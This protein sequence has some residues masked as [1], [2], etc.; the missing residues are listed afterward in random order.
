MV[1][2]L[3]V[4]SWEQSRINIF[5]G[6]TTTEKIRCIAKFS[7]SQVMTPSVNF[8]WALPSFFGPVTGLPSGNWHS[9]SRSSPETAPASHFTLSFSFYMSESLWEH[10]NEIFPHRC[11]QRSFY[12]WGIPI[13][14][15]L[16]DSSFIVSLPSDS[17]STFSSSFM[18][19]S[20]FLQC[21]GIGQQLQE[22]LFSA[23]PLS[24]CI[25]LT[26]WI[27]GAFALQAAPQRRSL[28]C[29]GGGLLS[30]QGEFGAGD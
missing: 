25:S 15:K 28:D 21:C 26:A 23:L 18:A 4:F 9:G 8:D 24:R 14:L 20:F 11:G 17:F 12:R 1:S 6:N 19:A 29:K 3:W 2:S 22:N 5:Q 7:P 16:R 27:L 13:I 30:V 10:L